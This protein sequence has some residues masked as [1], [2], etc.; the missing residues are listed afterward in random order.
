MCR[1]PENVLI[2]ASLRQSQAAARLLAAVSVVMLSGLI[3]CTVYD[4]GPG[5]P[6]VIVPG[7]PVAPPPQPAYAPPPPPPPDR[8]AGGHVTGEGGRRPPR[9]RP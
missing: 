7:V 3:G 5:R 2:R 9:P 6:P 4:Y 1:D 8:P